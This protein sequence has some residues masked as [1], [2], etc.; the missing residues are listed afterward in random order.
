MVIERSEKNSLL[1]AQRNEAI[2]KINEI[3]SQNLM[4]LAEYEYEVHSSVDVFEDLGHVGERLKSMAES[5]QLVDKNE[6]KKLS[7]RLFDAREIQRKSDR[8]AWIQARWEVL[9]QTCRFPTNDD[10]AILV[11]GY[12]MPFPGSLPVLLK[13]DKDALEDGRTVD[14]YRVLTDPHDIIPA[15]SKM[16]RGPIR[17][18]KSDLKTLNHLISE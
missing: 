6:L 2:S 3:G 1:H 5:I 14:I 15:Q 8:G 12:G 7:D 11:G 4:S 10:E 13:S 16:R 9:M 17:L 18:A